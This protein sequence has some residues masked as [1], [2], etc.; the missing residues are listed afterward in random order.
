M[1]FFGIEAVVDNEYKLYD[2]R[3]GNIF[4]ILKEKNGKY[5]TSQLFEYEPI[6]DELKE[7]LI[8]II[9]KG[10]KRLEIEELSFSYDKVIKPM[11]RDN[12]LTQLGIT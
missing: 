4:F 7:W 5:Y 2:I 8:S 1:K 12:K 3:G 11:F 10:Y 9:S 6:V